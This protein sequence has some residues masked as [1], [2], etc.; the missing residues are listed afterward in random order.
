MV[1][2]GGFVRK[3]ENMCSLKLFR[4]ISLLNVEGKV[5]MVVLVTIITNMLAN[6]NKVTSIERE[7]LPGNGRLHR[8]QQC[9]H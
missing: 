1:V 2:E 5:C 9:G 6:N 8:I 4:T 3:E 7:G